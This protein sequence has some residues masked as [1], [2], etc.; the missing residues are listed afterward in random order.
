MSPGTACLQAALA[1]RLKEPPPSRAGLGAVEMVSDAGA[2][3]CAQ[4]LC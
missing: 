3:L 4:A 1:A 2:A